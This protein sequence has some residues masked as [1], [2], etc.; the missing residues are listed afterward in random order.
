LHKHQ[1]GLWEFPGGKIDDGET[2]AEALVRE[3]QEELAIVATAFR[4]LLT[5]EHH[6]ADKSVRLQV[7][8]VTAFDG[9]AHGAEGQPTLWVNAAELANYAF[10][11]ANTAI[12]KA[13]VLPERYGI[14]PEP[15]EIGGD[16]LSWL[17]ERLQTG[18]W[19]CLRA[20]SLGKAEYL[21]LAR[22]VAVLAQQRQA[23]LM[24]H[25]HA[26]ALAQIPSAAG[27]HLTSMQ[28]GELALWRQ[29]LGEQCY[30]A[31]SCHDRQELEQ[32][33][34][35]GADLAT[36]SP[37]QATAS[38]LGQQGMGWATFGELVQ[39]A[40]LPVFALGGMTADDIPRAQATGAQGVAGIRGLFAV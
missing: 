39:Q 27:V 22:Q 19:L 14:T 7:F 24:L 31:V 40:R 6:Y 8:R 1:G 30:L 18:M 13:A 20:R 9:E 4:P 37:V 32:A 21:A 3:L 10:P 34:R 29:Q 26:D 12:V 36:L 33:W 23:R 38:H 17:H 5:V 15:D 28:A 35:N 2:A 11:A 16:L 25:G